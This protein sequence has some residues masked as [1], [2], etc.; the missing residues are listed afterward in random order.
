MAGQDKKSVNFGRLAKLREILGDSQRAFAAKCGFDPKTVANLEHLQIIVE[1][2]GANVIWLVT[3][4]GSILDDKSTERG[5]CTKT[6][7]LPIVG[8]SQAGHGGRYPYDWADFFI[9]KP[10]Y[11]KRDDAFGIIV[12]GDSM[13]PIS[14]STTCAIFA[15][16]T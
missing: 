11:L 7:L 15:A 1:T 3:G 6:K 2:T 14:R 10:Q 4:K 8:E 16:P 5:K 9:L 13:Q 12:R